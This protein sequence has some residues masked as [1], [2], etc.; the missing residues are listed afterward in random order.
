MIRF[1]LGALGLCGALSPLGSAQDASALRVF[2]RGGPKTHG[3]GEH[4]HPRFVA[5][6]G[7]FLG[8]RGAKV[9]AALEFPTEEQLARTDVLVLYAAD[10]GSIHG[11]DRA[12]L[13]RYLARGGG[14]VAIHDA[15]CGDDPQWFK[16]VI[17]GAWEHGHSKWHMGAMGLYFADR[18][19]PITRGVANFDFEDELYTDLHVMPQARVLANG[20]HDVFEITPQMWVYEP[21][22]YRAFVAIQ[23]HYHASFSNPAWR[24]LLLRGI[25]WAG[26][27]DADLLTTG[28]EREALRYPKGGPLKPEAAAQA[29]QLQEGF[30][31]SLVAAEPL[32]V[33][34]ISLDWD[35]DGRLWVAQTPG[36]PEKSQFSG[37]P[38]RDHIDV[39]SDRDGD[40]RMDESKT[41]CEG[42]DLVT[43]FVF[44]ERGVIASASPEILS[45]QDLD[46]DGRADVR[47][48][49]FTGFGFGDTH[50]VVSNLRWGL[51]GWIYATQGYSGNA[52]TDIRSAD[53]SR[54]FG[55]IGN[56]IFRFRPD[57]SAIEMVSS[58]G[59]NT[60]G[61]D[62]DWDGEL[63]FTMANGAHLRH[64]VIPERAL[65]GGRLPG[66]ETWADI[67]DHDRVFPISHAERTPYVQIDFVGGFTAASGSCVYTGGA[68]PREFWGSHFV[69]EPTV[70][71]V[72]QDH[73]EPR[74]A[75]Y[76]ASKPREAEFLASADLWF[77][78]VHMRVGPDGALYV[79][80]FYNQAVVHNDTRGPP[81]G[82]TNAAIRPDRDHQHGRI[83]RVQ[84]ERALAFE[85]PRMSEASS[86]QLVGMLEHP[87]AWQRAS[88]QRLLCERKAFDAEPAL[89]RLAREGDARTKVS[90]LWTLARLGGLEKVC[91]LETL[92]EDPDS[93]VR[94][95]A[96]RIA[97]DL[98]L[99]PSGKAAL[100]ARL[101]DPDARV[102]L[103]AV[104]ALA[105]C[106]VDAGIDVKMQTVAKDDWAR[107][108]IL[109][110][111]S[112][113]PLEVLRAALP[114]YRF[115]GMPAFVEQLAGCIGRSGNAEEAGQAVQLLS[116][117]IDQ[118]ALMV[119]AALRRLLREFKGEAIPSASPE[120]LQAL[121]KLLDHREFEVAV[122]ALP[123]ATRWDASGALA[124]ELEALGDRLVARALDPEAAPA[125][126]LSCLRSLIAIPE[127]RAQA[128]KGAEQLLDP[129]Q[130]PEIQ[131]AVIEELGRSAD[132]EAGA[133]LARRYIALGAQAREQAFS[134]LIARPRWASILL[135]E[136]EAKRLSANDLGPHRVFQLKSH[137]DGEVARR[138]KAAL[139]ASGGESARKLEELLASLTP[140]VEQPGD[141][142]R[143]RELFE[144]NC[145]TC[146]TFQG[147]GANVGPDLTGMGAHGARAL[148]PMILDPNA[149]VEAGYVEYVAKTTDERL[150][151][152]VLVRE[153]PTSI[154][155]RSTA[156]DIEVPR[157][158]IVSLRSTGRSPMPTGLES[159]TPEGLRD[160]LAYLCA[161][162][163]GYRLLDLE[164]LC[165]ANSREGM[166]D[167]RRDRNPLEFTR[168]GITK[169]GG[170]PFEVLDPGRAAK[171]VLALKGG[172]VADW[173]SKRDYPQRVE[174]PVG[175]ALERVHVLGGIAAWGFPCS[176]DSRP[177]LEWTW[178]YAGGGSET[179]VLRDGV[180]FADWI[181][182]YD[183]PGS[184]WVEGLVREG[185]P[186]Q[187]RRFALAPSRKEV[188]ESIVLASFDNDM[189][190]TFVALTAELAGAP[191]T[192]GQ[193]APPVTTPATPLDV[194]V[195]GGG[196]SHDFGRWFRD[197]D[198]ATLARAGLTKTRY[199][200]APGEIAPQLAS[201]KVLCLTNNQPLG[202][203][204]LRKGVFDFVARGGGLLLVHPATWYNWA[205]WPEY[206]AKLVG[207]G[208]RG[209]ESYGEFEVQVLNTGHPLSAGVPETFRITDELYRFE[210]DAEG[211]EIEVVAIGRSLATGE[212][213]PVVWT[214][215]RKSGRTVCIT[216]GH[217]GAAHEHPAYR[218]LL[219]N[220]VKWLQQP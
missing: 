197:A 78:P 122:A 102:V 200:E 50:A 142:A 154:V 214:V 181:G 4:D 65:A 38:P 107:S 131:L 108:A 41:F 165:T 196:S 99:V 6:F 180:E 2:L 7:P 68:W 110:S 140:I 106:P 61:L 212:R 87:N 73:L 135:E 16:T 190:P 147:K 63:F 1:L 34:P 174:V 128:L 188:I 105:A 52:S 185:G 24:T 93:G 161:G 28:P 91:S 71:L 219:A 116:K 14:I 209:H 70:N 198:L 101:S 45:L 158:E 138:A 21:G 92:L 19:H 133:V 193:E 15:V 26:K 51:D 94:K 11:E 49:L 64:V 211:E 187:V 8:E 199:T 81:H 56:G 208:A 201:L 22:A 59:S 74:G 150:S 48:V 83:W 218:T 9:E 111:S 186:G 156:G 169:L 85:P 33:K 96:V 137:P 124:K 148:L 69:A 88:A 112:R 27:R 139:E 173:C 130:A 53:G 159:L 103:A 5:E 167:P 144:Q 113:A 170:V 194:L 162:E 183:V 179:V 30:Q 104:Q 40:G 3:E 213:Y 157:E 160:V 191:K 42:L 18:E 172:R 220:S 25:A 95:N 39:L 177:I 127:R 155:L 109:S 80:D 136:I 98:G 182:R 60:W 152:G 143:G 62:F 121:A 36:Y 184:E 44:H 31:L 141:L 32:I 166:Y 176:R 118:E 195:V 202:G 79:L 189:S 178:K 35:P 17:G 145:A 55:K 97:S 163:Q 126:R 89:G 175:F 149:A 205:D 114:M 20:F 207:G 119:A 217:D 66:V 10:A 132:D 57:G 29:L 23:G 115:E 54:R 216:L 153:S 58:Y 206:N 164:P 77:R 215:A 75:T 13:E 117:Q 12:H 76:L 47:S 129:L 204:A 43:S 146:H 151:A 125:A 37:H 120:L 100:A 46:G 123:F 82:P 171:N 134:R 84:H 90:A 168:T 72:H 203:Q 210:P 86:A 192:V 67:A